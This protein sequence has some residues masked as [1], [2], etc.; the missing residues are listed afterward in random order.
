MHGLLRTL[1]RLDERA[2]LCGCIGFDPAIGTYTVLYHTK[3][4]KL[5][6]DLNQLD[7]SRFKLSETEWDHFA[8]GTDKIV[9]KTMQNARQA[10]GAFAGH[11]ILFVASFHDNADT[12]SQFHFL[13]YLCSQQRPASM[14]ILMPFFPTGTLER[15]GPKE[16]GIVPTAATLASML[17]SLPFQ[18]GVRVMTYDVHA[19]A[20][21]FFF[22]GH[23][24]LTTHSA[25]PVLLD[26][27]RKSGINCVV[28]PDDGAKKRFGNMFEDIFV[29]DSGEGLEASMKTEKYKIVTCIK[30]H[31]GN[32]SDKEVKIEG[33]VDLNGKNAIIID[34]MTRSGNTLFECMRA[35][36][37]ANATSVSM[38]VTHGAFLADFYA[39][40]YVY[41]SSA[42]NRAYIEKLKKIYTTDSVQDA[43]ERIDGMSPFKMREAYLKMIEKLIAERRKTGKDENHMQRLQRDLPGVDFSA[44]KLYS[45]VIPDVNAEDFKNFV[46]SNNLF[47]VLPLAS[48]IVK[49]L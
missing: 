5:A 45:V 14:T 48:T 11:N 25:I 17:S 15:I 36:V 37:D 8:D 26:A 2:T 10:D 24:T 38:F 49:D 41:L 39:C 9:N 44:G 43:Q 20:E 32:G 7:N 6:K 3:A 22:N 29:S 33:E 42:Q 40:F 13:H 47:Q 23:A 18:G 4:E 19:L 16:E 31:V 1:Q 21:K 30:K 27:I 28:F 46:T 34:D 12:L 35:V